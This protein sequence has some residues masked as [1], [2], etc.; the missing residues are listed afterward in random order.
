MA[1]SG[2]EFAMDGKATYYGFVNDFT[3]VSP[4]VVGNKRAER[5]ENA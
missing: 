5:S 3:N 2:S 4:I 1:V